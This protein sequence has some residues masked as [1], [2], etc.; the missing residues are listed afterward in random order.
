MV[1]MVNDAKEARA[2]LDCMKYMP[3]G[4][5]GVALGVAHDHYTGGAVLEKLAAANAR[6]TLFAQIETAAG[7]KNAEEIAAIDGVDCLWVGHFDLIVLAR[8]PRSS[9]TIRSSRTRSAAPTPRAETQQGLRPAR[10]GRRHRRL[11]LR[12]GLRLH[13]LFRRRLGVPD[14]ACGRRRRH[15]QGL[16]KGKAGGSAPAPAKKRAKA[17]GS[18]RWSGSA[19]R[20]RETSEGRRQSDLPEL[21]PDADHAKPESGSALG[22][23]R[24]QR[25][26][27]ERS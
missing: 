13:L 3:E 10:A 24:R 17:I 9:S 6:S 26:A 15:P 1:P 4:K 12:S 7:V 22:R 21:R 19:S 20:S 2:I 18:G 5:R 8:H 14:G 23:S 25:H 16:R 27:V 11:H